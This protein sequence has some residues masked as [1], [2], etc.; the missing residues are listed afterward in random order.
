MRGPM[1]RLAL[2]A[3]LASG[4]APALAQTDACSLTPK[5]ARGVT[6][7]ALREL[8]AQPGF[9]EQRGLGGTG[10]VAQTRERGLGGTGIIGI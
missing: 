1:L 4:L 9:S 10:A 6:S 7:N 2:V 8:V 3:W 5:E